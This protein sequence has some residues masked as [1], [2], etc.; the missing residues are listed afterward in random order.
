MTTVTT[1]TQYRIG[2]V[3]LKTGQVRC[4]DCPPPREH[5]PLLSPY[6]LPGDL[7]DHCGSVL[8][9]RPGFDLRDE[10]PGA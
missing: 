3:D 4:L 9:P 10:P 6:K 1:A 8:Q 7:C 5:K 2:N